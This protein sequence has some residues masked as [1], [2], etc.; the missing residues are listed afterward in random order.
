MYISYYTSVSDLPD[1]SLR[2]VD[3]ERVFEGRLEMVYDGA[4]GTICDN[5][6]TDEDALVACHQ[7]GWSLF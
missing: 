2:V 5:G 1:G 6:W 7:L 4:W 3:G